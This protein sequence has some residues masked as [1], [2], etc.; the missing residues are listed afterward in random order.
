MGICYVVEEFD[1]TYTDDAQYGHV[2]FWDNR[3]LSDPE[4]FE[5]YYGYEYFQAIVNE[6]IPKKNKKVMIAGCGTSYFIDDMVADG[7]TDI[8]GVDISRVAI[9]IMKARCQDMAGVTFL[10][11]TMVDTDLPEKSFKAI[12]DKACFDSIICN[13]V[14]MISIRQYLFEID[15]LLEED[16]VFIVISHGNPEQRL[17]YLEQYDTDLPGTK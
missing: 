5:W 3:Y 10:Q 17:V 14:G 6:A 4:P 2:Q 8:L 13:G 7:F 1:N 11:G 12:I 9:E 15:R 16:G